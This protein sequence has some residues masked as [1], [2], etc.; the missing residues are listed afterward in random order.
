MTSLTLT[1][2]PVNKILYK[3]MARKLCKRAKK[4]HRQSIIGYAMVCLRLIR[5]VRKGCDMITADLSKFD[6]TVYNTIIYKLKQDGCM[7]DE[8]GNQIIEIRL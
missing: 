1:K 5:N 7:I 2:S 6:N 4:I 3:I 8:L